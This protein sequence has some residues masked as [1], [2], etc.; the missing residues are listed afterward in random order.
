LATSATVSRDISGNL[1]VD[2]YVNDKF[3]KSAFPTVSNTE[4]NS[5]TAGETVEI[6]LY[7]QSN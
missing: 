4:A 6:D 3:A 5:I 7:Q 1:K 2:L